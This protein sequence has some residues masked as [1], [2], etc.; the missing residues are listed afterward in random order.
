[1]SLKGI[2]R[3][4][5]IAAGTIAVVTV[6]YAA[7]VI[8]AAAEHHGDIDGPAFRWGMTT[9][10]ILGGVWII[11][12]VIVSGF[13]QVQRTTR[14]RYDKLQAEQPNAYAVAG[15]VV[16][17]VLRVLEERAAEDSP[18]VRLIRR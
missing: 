14:E 12:E 16:C 17:E 2:R 1:M 15:Q 8:Q 13:E 6:A 18:K 3:G 9:L 10:I 4:V 11:T 5:Q 7:S